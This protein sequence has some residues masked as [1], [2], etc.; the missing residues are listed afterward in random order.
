VGRQDRS[1]PPG[2]LA[3]STLLDVLA[4][5]QRS[6]SVAKRPNET[7]GAHATDAHIGAA[8]GFSAAIAARS[9]IRRAS[10]PAGACM[11]HRKGYSHSRASA[12][13]F[14][15]CLA[16]PVL[17]NWPVVA[18]AAKIFLPWIQYQ[19]DASAPRCQLSVAASGWQGVRGDFWASEPQKTK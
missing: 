6:A 2:F 11:Q 3:Q 9:A 15:C 14:S 4:R 13:P 12:L 19:T 1:T 18:Q 8:P 16:C 17:R 7:Q 5:V 10:A